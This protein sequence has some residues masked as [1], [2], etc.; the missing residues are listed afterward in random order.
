[1]IKMTK[2]IKITFLVPSISQIEAF[3]GN[4]F[5]GASH[6]SKV[7]TDDL[8]STFWGGGY[9]SLDIIFLLCVL[10]IELRYFKF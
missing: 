3:L 8:H 6:N 2:M 1:M 5:Y 10:V 4:D 9:E 7:L